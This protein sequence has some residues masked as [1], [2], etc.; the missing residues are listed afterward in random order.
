MTSA[1]VGSGA[2]VL[3]FRSMV[4]PQVFGSA[5]PAAT[6]P[7]GVGEMMVRTTPDTERQR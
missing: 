2:A 5:P 1:M 6:A 7:G 3:A 4:V